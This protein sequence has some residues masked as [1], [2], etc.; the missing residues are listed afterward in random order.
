MVN[1]RRPG[2]EITHAARLAALTGFRQGDLL[3]LSWTHVGAHAIE[4]RTGKS[5][6]RRLASAPLT[7]EIC[8]LLDEIKIEANA[9][10]AR[11]RRVGKVD[12]PIATT[13]L[14]NSRGAP[15]RGFNS[16]WTR[17]MAT[18]WPKGRDPHFHDLRGTAATAYFRAD[19]TVQEIAQITGWSEDRVERQI[20]RTPVAFEVPD[21]YDS[22]IVG[23]VGA[24]AELPPRDK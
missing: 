3:R 15:W 16:S 7:A 21:A 8:A 10:T 5:G 23:V 2:P 18:A 22:K 19:F 14:T 17:A 11:Q 12:R 1:K 20:D 4:M 9:R 13:I 24:V 6:G